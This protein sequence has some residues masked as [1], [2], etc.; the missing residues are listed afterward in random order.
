M[1][2][3]SSTL[4]HSYLSP[5]CLLKASRIAIAFPDASDAINLNIKLS[6]H[7][8]NISINYRRGANREKQ[9]NAEGWLNRIEIMYNEINHNC[10]IE[11]I[12]IQLGNNA[13]C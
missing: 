1:K 4:M 2:I 6:K 5:K 3:A 13:T 11:T 10:T 7:V 12:K 9:T 8:V